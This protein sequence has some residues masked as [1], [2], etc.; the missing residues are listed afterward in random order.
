M[1]QVRAV[2]LSGYVEVANFV[3]LDGRRMLRE[4]GIALEALEDPENRLPAGPVI[5]LLE[6]SAE[7]SGCESFGLLM[8]EA[9]SFASLGPLS[10][11]LERLPNVREIVCAGISFQRHLNDV[12]TISMEDVGDTCVVR[13]DVEP[14]LW[15]VQVIDNSVAMAYRVLTHASGNRWQPACIHV[16]RPAPE[17]MSAWRRFYT[18]GIEFE[19]GFN[20]LSASCAS[21]QIAN[22]LADEVM[23]RHARR[24]LNLVP[25]D[26]EPG[27]ASDRVRRV[28]TLLLP[29]GRATLTQAAAQ[30]GVSPRSLQRQLGEEGHQ[31]A[32]LLDTVRREL[33][34]AYLAGSNRPV[35]SIAGLL[36]YA[37]PSSF[38][39]W[40]AGQFG[41]SPQAWRAGRAAP[42]QAG[43]PPT[44]RR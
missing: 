31:F 24:L 13:I 40:F 28:I 14:G 36:G 25:L 30:L 43:P 3:G 11:L 34:A 17:D 15:G 29:G 1:H 38:T 18:V 27:P 8:A 41:V 44:W 37:S 7:R 10:L 9:R 6:R 21:M 26:R 19:A 22:P 32:D 5:Q 23:A 42:A 35:T 33:A 39:R 20:G 16:M 12:V 4:A 2:T